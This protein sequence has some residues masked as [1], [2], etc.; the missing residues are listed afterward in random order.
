MFLSVKE[1]CSVVLREDEIRSSSSTACAL[2]PHHQGVTRGNASRHRRCS[3]HL[4][5]Q[6]YSLCFE[7]TR[8]KP[9]FFVFL[10]LQHT[11]GS[12]SH[13]REAVKH[14]GSIAATSIGNRRY[15]PR[16]GCKFII[17]H[18]LCIISIKEKN[19]Q[20]YGQKDDIGNSGAVL[21]RG[22]GAW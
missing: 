14:P 3:K 19:Y 10:F 2:Q 20:S 18:Y 12:I 16:C 5:L 17:F 11:R 1:L 6:N 21:Q 22:G 7:S 15:W 8:I 4:L 13:N 9:S